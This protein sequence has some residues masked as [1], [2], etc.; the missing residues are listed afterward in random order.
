M[1]STIQTGPP[2]TIFATQIRDVEYSTTFDRGCLTFGF[3][4]G[5]NLF[6]T[7]INARQRPDIPQ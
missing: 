1:T 3:G 2:L 5:Y 7:Q 6:V 4:A